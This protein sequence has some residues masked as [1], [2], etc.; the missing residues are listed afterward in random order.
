M[1]KLVSADR[2]LPLPQRRSK[3]EALI[4]GIFYE[5]DVWG[6]L[7]QMKYTPKS[8][9]QIGGMH[10]AHEGCWKLLE[11]TTLALD[12]K[13]LQMMLTSAQEFN[14]ALCVRCAVEDLIS[15]TDKAY[16][17]LLPVSTMSKLGLEKL[18]WWFPHH[19]VNYRS[20]KVS[21]ALQHAGR[22]IMLMIGSLLFIL[23][24]KS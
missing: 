15:Q 23:H 9:V 5:A 7:T 6:R 8:Y 19:R 22:G 4:E 12:Q 10:K 1:G 11:T 16:D 14:I 17:S 3:A 21:C 18:V 13:A 20:L 2:Q 24:W